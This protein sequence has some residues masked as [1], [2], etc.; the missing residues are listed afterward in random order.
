M[1][2]FNCNYMQSVPLTVLV[3]RKFSSLY[4]IGE[5]DQPGLPKV[6]VF[7]TNSRK[8]SFPVCPGMWNVLIVSFLVKR[9]PMLFIA[10]V[11]QQQGCVY[12]QHC[13]MLHIFNV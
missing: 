12:V 4:C 8:V 10:P 5:K 7:L 1:L 9:K 6:I 13:S 3:E 11:F 2:Q